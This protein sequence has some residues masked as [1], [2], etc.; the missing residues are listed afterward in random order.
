MLPKSRFCTSLYT[1][2]SFPTRSPT[3]GYSNNTSEYEANIVQ[4]EL[5]VQI[6]FTSFTF[7]VDKVI[8]KK[9]SKEY[10][11]KKVE[12]ILDHKRAV[13]LLEQFEDFEIL[14]LTTREH[15]A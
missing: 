3:T 12:L 14:F 4:L 8:V 1:M 10:S 13:K 5:A 11:V 9:L 6:P 15:K 2:H 7:Y